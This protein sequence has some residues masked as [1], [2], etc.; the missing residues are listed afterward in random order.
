[1]LATMAQPDAAARRAHPYP[2]SG[3]A[4]GLAR[5][6]RPSVSGADL[7]AAL[8]ASVAPLTLAIV[9]GL[10]LLATP[11]I[12]MDVTGFPSGAALDVEGLSRMTRGLADLAAILAVALSRYRLGL[13][14][15]L[16]VAPWALAPVANTMAWGWWLAGLAVLG[17]AVFDGA[18]KRALGLAALVT[19]LAVAYCSS[20]IYWSVPFVGPV[21]LYNTDPD[22]WFDG[23]RQ[24]YL[25]A[26]LGAVGAVVLT[27]ALGR[28]G[29]RRLRAAAAPA[30][31]ADGAPSRPPERA[32]SGPAERAPS[33][34][35]ERTLSEPWAERIDLLTRRERQVLHALAKGLS[36]AEIARELVIGEETV[37]SHVSEVLRKLRCRDRVQAVIAAYESGLL[38]PRPLGPRP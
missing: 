3:G 22:R 36:N 17:V 2:P 20:G 27:A 19:A 24:F 7:R 6:V 35:P 11:R 29:V 5:P 8:I 25:A 30:S 9:V 14:C 13:A 4:A 15:G 10:V 23:T 32:P 12:R 31:P 34:P 33:G 18:R 26:Y 38:G 21:N 16:I 1:M 37:K 28:A